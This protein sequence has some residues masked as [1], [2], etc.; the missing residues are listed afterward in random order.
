MMLK[1]GSFEDGWID[2]PAGSTINQEPKYWRL[3]WKAVGAPLTSIEP[4]LPGDTE[5]VVQTVPECVHKLA[6]QLPPN[7]RPTG[8]DPLII[9]GR[10]VYKVFA[11]YGAFAARLEATIVAEPGA[12]VSV[13]VP[14]RVHQH[15][16]GDYGAAYW[17]AALGATVG[18]WL[19]FKRDFDDRTWTR[20]SLKARVPE[21]G[22]MTLS[23]E[24]ESHTIAGIDFFIDDVRAEVV[25]EPQPEPNPR[26]G[27]PREQYH[28]VYWFIPQHATLDQMRQA[29]EL[30]YPTRGTVGFSA[31]DAGIG[32]L[33][34]RDVHV[35]W[36]SD[37]DW[38]R[39]AL[40]DFFAR[41][42]PGVSVTH[43]ALF[44]PTEPEKPPP[45]QS[46]YSSNGIGLHLVFA[47]EGWLEYLRRGRP[48]LVKVFSAGD[49]YRAKRANPDCIV[50][51]RRYVPNDG[52]WINGAHGPIP[53]AARKFLGLYFSEAQ[54]AAQAFG[55]SEADLWCHIDVIESINEVIGT[56]DPETPR[57]VDFDV[58]FADLV[59]LYMDKTRA[60]IL[61]IPVGNPHESEVEEL[62]PAAE[63]AHEQGHYLAPHAYWTANPS[64]CWLEDKWEWHAG[65]FAQ[66][67]KV[68]VGHRFYPRYYFGEIGAV[69]SET[70]D[71]MHSGKGWRS[72]YGDFD[73]YIERLA[74]YNELLAKWNA[75][76]G[77]RALGGTVFT[78]SG[79]GWDDFAWS[80]DEQERLTRWAEGV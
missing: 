68:F 61:T 33:D 28:R 80:P 21:S 9:D 63:I 15:G 8:A 57:A 2:V 47:K 42:Y 22:L 19:T 67:D 62:L 51:W 54:A 77:N 58:E 4:D 78:Y 13:T 32:D 74:R 45:E 16:N 25:D 10:T 73:L 59:Y 6:I 44:D 66:W 29:C 31:D 3:S 79:W 24:F 72:A 26:R 40:D 64:H 76:H 17:R 69:Y 39:D 27:A 30:A 55:I 35:L 65:R 75:A 23:I 12:V 36:F 11:A 50:I 18:D 46:F 41:Y 5:S 48:R 60:G 71:D 37:G 1:N 34:E 53:D 52:E 38:D 7:E 14:V 70:G 43:E 49:A 56:F 20:C